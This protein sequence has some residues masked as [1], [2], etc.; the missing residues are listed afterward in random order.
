MCAIT[1]PEDFRCG[2]AGSPVGSVEIKLLSVPEAGYL[3]TN[4]L[5]QG[6]ILIRGP[7]VTKGYFKRPDLNEGS[8]YFYRRWLVPNGR[9]WAV[10]RGW[11]FD[12]YRPSKKSCEALW[13]RGMRFSPSLY[14]TMADHCNS[15]SHLNASSPYTNPAG[16][17]PISA[18]TAR[19]T[20]NNRSQS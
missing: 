13:W 17:S 8:I 2:I 6:E 16:S 15:T 19:L 12:Y 7:S 11:K 18:Y 3:A 9:C 4:E 14:V 10:E 20:Q 1:S 5:P